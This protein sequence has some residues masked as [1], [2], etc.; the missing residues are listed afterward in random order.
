[1]TEPKEPETKKVRAIDVRPYEWGVWC[2]VGDDKRPFVN[3][4]EHRAWSDDGLSIW[5]GLETHNSKNA[6]PDEEIDLV[7]LVRPE[8]APKDDQDAFL[9][10]RPV[11]TV[12]CATCGGKG[13]V[14]A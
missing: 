8:F 2:T 7:P 1:M 4:I 11:P 5:F 9:A 10:K 14:P 13:R 3:R 12:E 6:E